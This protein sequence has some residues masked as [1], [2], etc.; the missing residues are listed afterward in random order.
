MANIFKTRIDEIFENFF[1]PT[2]FFTDLS[3]L[4][5]WV[6]VVLPLLLFIPNIDEKLE[7]IIKQISLFLMLMYF[8]VYQIS[9]IY[10]L[11]QI[12]L[13]RREQL[14]SNALPFSIS[15][16]KTNQYY[17]NSIPLSVKKVGVNVMES[18]FFSSRIASYKATA[19]LI[20]LLIFTLVAVPLFKT[21]GYEIN[22]VTSYV[23]VLFSAEILVEFIKI[24]MFKS[25]CTQLYSEIEQL[26]YKKKELSDI[27]VFQYYG[28]YEA[29]KTSCGIFLYLPDRKFQKINEEISKEWEVKCE[30]LEIPNKENAQIKLAAQSMP[31]HIKANYGK[32]YTKLKSK[33][34]K[35]DQED[36]QE[37]IKYRY[38]IIQQRYADLHDKD[39]QKTLKSSEQKEL[40]ELKITLHLFSDKK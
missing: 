38:Y 6:N 36:L 24:F 11:P 9:N 15:D 26:L 7:V 3:S 13:K 34:P 23:R 40:E 25:R 16:S 10:F 14:L 2:K 33:Y 8:V 5:F 19:K 20:T 39:T 22:I 17:N 37:F 12:N 18:A 4:L 35:V 27:E 28:N 1:R 21:S 30:M 31:D 29:A 32:L